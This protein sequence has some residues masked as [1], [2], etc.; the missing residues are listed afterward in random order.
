MYSEYLNKRGFTD[1][2]IKQFFLKDEPERGRVI[3]P[4]RSI[5]AEQL[6]E[7]TNNYNNKYTNNMKYVSP[8]AESMP[9]GHS[10]F[11][12]LHML[13]D[14]G[15]KD[16]V[17]VE[18]E[19]N[20]MSFWKVGMPSLGIAGQSIPFN[21]MLLLQIPE[22]VERICVLY[23][24]YEFALKRALELEQYYKDSKKIF[25]ASYPDGRDAN[26][27]LKEERTKELKNL[28]HKAKP[29]YKGQVIEK[30]TIEEVKNVVEKYF[31]DYWTDTLCCID[32]VTSMVLADFT[33]P[34][35][36]ILVGSPSSGKTTVLDMFITAKPRLDEYVYRCDKFTPN[37]WLSHIASVKRKKLKDIHL[38][39]RIENKTLVTKDLA[40]LFSERDETLEENIGVATVVLD[41][42]GLST[43]SGAQGRVEYTGE[44]GHVYF[45]WLGATTPLK[46]RIWEAI[47]IKGSRFLFLNIKDRDED[48]EVISDNIY[49]K[50]PYNKKV[51]LCT[52]AV[53]KFV[54]YTYWGYE[55]YG[56]SWDR[57]KDKN[58]IVARYI[59]KFAKLVA[60]L[61]APIKVFVDDDEKTKRTQITQNLKEMPYR[62]TEQLYTIAR[63]NAANHR[64]T[65]LNLDDLK[66]VKYTA[67]SSV[68]FE[69][70]LTLEA[71]LSSGIKEDELPAIG[72]SGLVAK[73]NIAPHKARSLIELFGLL[74]ICEVSIPEP[75]LSKN[76]NYYY[77]DEYKMVLK[78]EYC[79]LLG[80]EIAEL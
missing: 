35:A 72:T 21:T 17:I 27:Y 41:G 36:L 31:P 14:N 49:S 34:I 10:W 55:R 24:D 74:E 12:G 53:A 44:E 79:W 70:K 26:D 23:D 76:D 73:L 13:K 47:G 68:P 8:N 62:L 59:I 69:R 80:K 15:T 28:I 29:Y 77:Q 51:A 20:C 2:I 7:R 48:E 52:E 50:I 22:S 60:S 6:Y 11:F 63:S 75:F 18:G 64:R 4:Y 43:D 37:S 66:V 1:N 67:L 71:L 33:S 45:C 32:V 39:P 40:C 25:V 38:L 5:L 65:E 57:E 16:L 30:I 46:Y 58:N 19:Y 56:L 42:R 9:G 61:R 78:K 54:R 3:I